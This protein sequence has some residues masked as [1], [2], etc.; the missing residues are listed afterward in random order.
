[1]VAP[2]IVGFCIVDV[3]PLGPV[4]AYVAPATLEAVRLNVEP[5]QTAPPFPAVGAAGIPFT[6]TAVAVDVATHPLASVI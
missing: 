5:S 4:H 6:V 1:M 3:N 2:G